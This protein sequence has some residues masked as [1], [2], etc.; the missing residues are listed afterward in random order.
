MSERDEREDKWRGRFEGTKYIAFAKR[1]IA[2]FLFLGW[3]A[4]EVSLPYIEQL[5]VSDAVYCQICQNLLHLE[6]FI[7][8]F[9]L[10]PRDVQGVHRHDVQVGDSY[11]TCDVNRRLDRICELK[12]V[13]VFLRLYSIG[14]R[15]INE[16]TDE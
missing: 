13:C 7:F 3:S 12:V 5:G 1:L 11:R 4:F 9:I 15:W 10:Q 6:V 16:C 2:R 14:D 8:L